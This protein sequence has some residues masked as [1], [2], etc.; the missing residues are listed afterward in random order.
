MSSNYKWVHNTYRLTVIVSSM[1]YCQ[2]VQYIGAFHV[3]SNQR[4]NRRNHSHYSHVKRCTRP[5]LLGDP[6]YMAIS[7]DR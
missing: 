7:G 5:A 6:R 4:V 3:Y 1:Q 2:I